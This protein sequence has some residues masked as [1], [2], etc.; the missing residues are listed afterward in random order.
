MA[1]TLGICVACRDGFDRVLELAKAAKAADKHVEIFF[2]GNG[3]YQSQLPNF[4]ELLA[5][6]P[7]WGSCS[8]FI[9]SACSF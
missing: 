1:Q 8:N 9:P 7:V 5:F 2:T 4:T 6:A 3:V